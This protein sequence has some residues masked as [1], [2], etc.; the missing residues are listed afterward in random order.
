MQFV[1]KGVAPIELQNWISANKGMPNCRFKYLEGGV[2]E[3][4]RDRLLSEQFYICCYTGLRLS[5]NNNHIEHLI[6]QSDSL[7]R[8]MPLETV[9][10]KNMVVCDNSEEFGARYK[11]D[12]PSS[13]EVHLFVKPVDPTC[14][15]RFVY[16]KNGKVEAMDTDAAATTTIEK[17]NLN[18]PKLLKLRLDAINNLFLFP[19]KKDVDYRKFVRNSIGRFSTPVDGKY[20]EFSFVL[21]QIL[22]KKLN[23]LK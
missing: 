19:P 5:L 12:W 8:N 20:H 3:V 18:H 16:K 14:R 1:E 15:T 10:Y 6:P 23:S 22:T 13:T 11:A 21:T 4:I 2:K 7:A 17:L 9:E